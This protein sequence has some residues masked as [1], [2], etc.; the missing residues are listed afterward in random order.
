MLYLATREGKLTKIR[1]HL[2]MAKL[3]GMSI[4]L[5]VLLEISC[6]IININYKLVERK[7]KKTTKTTN[8]FVVVGGDEM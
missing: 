1:V 2:I 5:S 7:K 8:I 3:F 6:Y 4:I